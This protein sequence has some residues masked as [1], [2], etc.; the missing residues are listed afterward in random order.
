MK[1][2][3]EDFLIMRE[4]IAF[5]RYLLSRNTIA[6]R[7]DIDLLEAYIHD[8]PNTAFLSLFRMHRAFFWQIVE[9]LH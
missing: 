1:K 9:I 6:G 2:I 5:V 4:V 7:H 3:F 8:Y